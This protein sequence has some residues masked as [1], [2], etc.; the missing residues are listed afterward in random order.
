MM[1][2]T[3]IQY[4]IRRTGAYVIDYLCIIG[5]AIVLLLVTVFIVQPDM[6]DETMR[7][8]GAAFMQLVGFIT[9]TG[10]VVVIMSLLEASRWQAS[11]GKM[12]MKLRVMRPDSRPLT[13]PRS[14]GRNALKF[15]P[16]EIAHTG[17]HQSMVTD[18]ALPWLGIVL[19]NVAMLLVV[20]YFSSC[21]M[22]RGRTVYDRAVNV[23][24]SDTRST[25]V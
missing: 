4:L 22:G 13:L 19:S 11:P 16:W 14:L 21:I 23:V 3:L 9:L 15:L 20:L 17:V 2:N 24:V 25:D 5:Y 12:L 10:P 8:G 1:S 7:I 18:H 6:S